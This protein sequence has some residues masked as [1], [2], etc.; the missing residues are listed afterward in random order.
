M[1]LF[2]LAYRYNILFVSET[3]VDTHGLI[4]PRALKQLFAGI[5]LGEICMIGLFSV[6]KA[7]GPVAL[8]VVFLIFTLLYHITLTRTLNPLMHGLPRTLQ[9]DGTTPQHAIN[10]EDGLVSSLTNDSTNGQ[11]GPLKKDSAETGKK[12]NMAVKFLQPW[13]HADYFTLRKLFYTDEHIPIPTQYSDQTEAEAFLPPSVA[14]KTP[15]L[16]IPQDPAGVSKQEV[17]LTSK[18][19]P[20]S[21][22]GC[23]MDDKNKLSWDTET[24]RPPIWDEKIYY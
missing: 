24:A 6:S 21:D 16:W 10:G 9:V 20:I 2:Y 17:T 19:I 18:V 14:S 5:Y 22:E 13:K 11:S 4:Y 12:P 8:M 23:T 1:G 7:G 3:Q 15:I